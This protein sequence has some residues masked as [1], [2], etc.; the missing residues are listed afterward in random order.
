M[1]ARLAGLIAGLTLALSFMSASSVAVAQDRDFKTALEECFWGLILTSEDQRGLSLGLNVVSGGLGTYAYISATAS[2]DTFCAEKTVAT[3]AFVKEAFPNLIEDA[4][5]G[6]GQY[7][8]AALELA[9]CDA[10]GSA[11]VIPALR[12]DL[13]GALSA[14]AYNSKTSNDKAFDLYNSLITHTD[15]HCPVG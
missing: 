1:K 10:V 6:E 3:A 5:R 13:A 12:T 14:D 7:L 2:P 15:T 4:V 9:G 11:L 8:N